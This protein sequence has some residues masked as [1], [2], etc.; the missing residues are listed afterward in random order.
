MKT[1]GVLMK[2]GSILFLFAFAWTFFITEPAAIATV[3]TPPPDH[4]V[5][6]GHASYYSYE[7]A[8]KPM[9]NGKAFDPEKRTCASW[10]YKF[11]T[12]LLVES[13]DTG[14]T[15]EVIVTD[16]GPNKRLVKEG[17]IIDLSKRAFEDICALKKGLT[18]VRV[19]MRSSQ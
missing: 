14:R 9:A 12:V 2:T 1:R 17:R 19:T 6:S 5:M 4:T 16:R 3:E 13:L 10:F 8:K 18:R 11:G 7:C 15:T